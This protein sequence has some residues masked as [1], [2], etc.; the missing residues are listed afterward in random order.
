MAAGRATF[1]PRGISYIKISFSLSARSR[2]YQEAVFSSCFVVPPLQSFDPAAL[3]PIGHHRDGEKAVS[4]EGKSR[5]GCSFFA[6]MALGAFHLEC[7]HTFHIIDCTRL[8]VYKIHITSHAE[9]YFLP[10]PLHW[11]GH[12]TLEPPCFPPPPCIF[13]VW[14]IC[15]RGWWPKKWG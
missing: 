10:H 15:R 13:R 2:R 1:E 3:P 14:Q 4:G 7:P 12:H 8:L 9:S 6:S 11:R 5:R